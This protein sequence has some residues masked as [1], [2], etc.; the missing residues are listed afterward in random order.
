LRERLRD[1]E[2]V[3]QRRWWAL[4]AL[5]LSLTIIGIDNTILNVALPT[6]AHPTAAGGLGATG[7]ELQWIVDVYVLVFAGLLL[8]AGAL[9]DRF[10]RYRGLTFGLVLFGA[11]SAASAF[12]S[13]ASVLIGT[14]AVMGIGAAF[15]MPATL[16][17]ITNVFHDPHERARAIGAWAGVAAV[18]IGIG[19][20]IGGVLLEHFWWGS[21]FFVNV[22]VVVAALVLGF[23]LLPESRDP[24]APPLDPLGSILSIAGLTALLWGIIEGPSHGWTSTAVVVAFVVGVIVVVAFMVWELRCANPMLDMRFFE[25]RRFSAASAAITL[26]YMALFGTIFLLTQY[27]QSVLDYSAVEAGA[28]FMPM[29]ALMVV[30]APLSP[31]LVA[32]FGSKLVVAVGMAM[33]ALSLLL[34]VTFDVHTSVWWVILVTVPLGIGMAHVMAPAT[35]SIMGSLPREKAGVGSA[36]NDTTRQVGGAIGV[37]LLGSIVSSHFSSEMRTNL[38]AVLPE[39]ALHRAEDSVGAALGVA[40]SAGRGAQRV[41]EA[42]HESFVSGMHLALW[43]AVVIVVIGVIAVAVWLPAHASDESLD[44]ATAVDASPVGITG[45]DVFITEPLVDVVEEIE[46]EHEQR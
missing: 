1:P 10:G 45:V 8:T 15:I 41:V 12:A 44:H 25:N 28:V 3:H 21:V 46:Y 11:G 2:Y 43:V 23:F 32:R 37:A 30:L 27:F 6:L 9:G 34:M 33:T 35:E 16:S 26:T 40:G 36:M 24:A 22:P 38:R 29:A 31:K 20:V 14:R 39:G 42:A 4:I 17:L 19:P 5:C 7:S 13:S 18:G